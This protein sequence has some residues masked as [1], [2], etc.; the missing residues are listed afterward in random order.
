[1]VCNVIL[2]RK[3]CAVWMTGYRRHK[4]NKKLKLKVYSSFTEDTLFS[5]FHVHTVHLDNYQSFFHQL[6]HNWTVVKTI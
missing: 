6:M 4:L 5:N 2:T 3:Y 1:M